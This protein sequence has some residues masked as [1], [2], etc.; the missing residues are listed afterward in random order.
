MANGQ[1]PMKARIKRL[2]GQVGFVAER[3]L[4]DLSRRLRE[5][6]EAVRPVQILPY[7]GYGTAD[8][9]LLQGRVLEDKGIRPATDTDRWW[10]NAWRMYRRFQSDEVPGARLQLRHT[11]TT[12]DVL[13]DAEGFFHATLPITAPLPHNRLW[14][15]VSIR[16]LERVVPD[17]GPVEATGH[18]L[19]PRD[20][21]FGVI[22]DIDDTIL[23]SHARNKPR[24]ALV[25]L[26]GNAH[27]RLPFAGVAAFY[28]ALQ[29]G[30]EGTAHN[31]IFYVSNSPW[32]LYDFLVD[33]MR[34]Q[35][36]PLGP[37]FLR[38]YGLNDDGVVLLSDP[39]HKRERIEALLTMYPTLPFLLIG[40]SGEQDPELYAQVVEAHPGRIQAIYIRNVTDGVRARQVQALAEATAAR[41]V[42]MLLSGD[43]VAAAEHAAAHGFIAAAE[44]S[45]VREEAR[46]RPGVVDLSTE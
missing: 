12:L 5:R 37:L 29:A 23:L 15:E 45:T 33:F 19:V 24:L 6:L 7:R 8:R 3:E 9:L 39:R 35:D 20:P 1:H 28:R 27:T 2:L 46:L 22:S 16:L 36:I 32:N 44:V 43:T 14:H 4:D 18:V 10:D 25:M 40:D 30:A 21:A 26:L 38:D 11:S 34:V 17:Q 41:G 13:T 31:P 42:P